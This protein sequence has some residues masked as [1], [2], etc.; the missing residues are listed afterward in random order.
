[1]N[2]VGVDGL[3]QKETRM[4][5]FP[6]F[7]IMTC[8]MAAGVAQAETPTLETVRTTMDS[9]WKNVA[10][11]SSDV[12]MNFLMPV[13]QEPLSLTGTGDLNYLREK[14]KDKYRQ[15]IVA[16]VPEPFSM[17]MKLD[18]LFDGDTVYTTTEIMGQKQSHQGKPSLEQSA[19]PPGG[20]RLMQSLE[21]QMTITV[22]PSEEL[23]GHRV[24]VLEG[25]AREPSAP[26]SKALFYIDM[27]LGIQRKTEIYQQDG[28][29][30]VAVLYENVQL[31]T[32]PDP[33]L[34]KPAP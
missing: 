9:A 8:L 4:K 17:E 24:F 30:G 33:A 29:V 25:K 22:L 23:D 2:P 6:R 15:R 12:T 18:V 10:S 21:E 5:L 13:G 32:E 20:T 31:N 26:Y 34:F 11:F 16:R 7:A 19:L 28:T 27:E 1:M 14:G 3:N